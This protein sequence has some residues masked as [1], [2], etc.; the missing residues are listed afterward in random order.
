[1][2]TNQPMNDHLLEGILFGLEK[3]VPF[4]I[5]DLDKKMDLF[6]EGIIFSALNSS[7]LFL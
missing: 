3:C 5:V 6:I 1:M 7:N 4:I 2:R